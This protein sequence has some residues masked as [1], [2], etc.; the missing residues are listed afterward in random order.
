MMR[1]VARA[2]RSGRTAAAAL[3]LLAL[4]P[5]PAR[6]QFS[7]IFFFGDSFTDTGNATGLAALNGLP[8][9][10]AGYPLAGRFSNGPV[11]AEV[12]AQRLGLPNADGP[13]WLGQGTNFAIGGATTGLLGLLNTPTGLLSQGAQFASTLPP[14]P[15][16]PD[17]L[18]VIWGGGNDIINAVSLPTAAERQL[19]VNQAVANL[20]TLI[21]N[22]VA[23][24][25]RNF[26]VPLLPNVG[27]APLFASNATNAG[28][29]TALTNTFNTLL[30][31][32]VQTL[33]ANP[34]VNAYS[35]NVNNLLTNLLMDAA[36]GGVNYGITN[37]TVPCLLLPN[38]AVAC[39]SAIFV[40]QRHPTAAVHTLIANAAYNRL[41]LQVDVT[42][43]PEPST[44]LL[45]GAGLAVVGVLVRRRRVS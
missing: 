12:L 29:A 36:N 35:L 38:P 8:N 30:G 5:S 27:V 19:A 20:N 39:N 2:L 17:A 9:P 4:A 40:D 21:S 14:G 7:S 31:A 44:V 13:A 45:M 23:G 16:A 32:G 33:D 25:A 1:R 37:A 6:A 28:I 18:F 26:L 41:V 3:A 15:I 24:G 34:F 11:Y 42:V 43:A 10:T 22:L